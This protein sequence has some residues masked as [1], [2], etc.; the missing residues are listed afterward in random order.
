ME[1]I[2]NK[3][4][5]IYNS[6]NDSIQLKAKQI[7]AFYGYKEMEKYDNI[8]SYKIYNNSTIDVEINYNM[9]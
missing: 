2:Q 1:E 5:E 9:N 8:S 7:T 3:A 6:K 4:V